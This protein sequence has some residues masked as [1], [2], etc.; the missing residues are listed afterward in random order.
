MGKSP[1]SSP[2]FLPKESIFLNFIL[3]ETIW[4]KTIQ[5]TR[6]GTSLRALIHLA[7]SEP[8]ILALKNPYSWGH[9]GPPALREPHLPDISGLQ[10]ALQSS[11]ALALLLD[12]WSCSA[13]SPNYNIQ[14]N[15]VIEKNSH[16]PRTGTFLC[17]V[18]SEPQCP[19]HQ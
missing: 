6:L 15:S 1:F 2:S 13:V 16:R 5:E 3:P 7:L 11:P 9:H 18:T 4:M 10:T 17:C 19:P 8:S 14:R 12:P